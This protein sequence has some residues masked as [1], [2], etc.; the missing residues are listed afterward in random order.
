MKN[1][2]VLLEAL[3][4]FEVELILSALFCRAASRVSLRTRITQNCGA[5][6]LVHK[7]SGLLPGHAGVG[8][9]RKR[10]ID[11]PLGGGNFRRLLRAQGAVP[12]EHLLL[13]RAP[14]VE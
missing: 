1:L 2:N 6:L 11:D 7:N 14:V 10:L 12:S 3:T 4:V 5:E 8:G 13:E 9:C